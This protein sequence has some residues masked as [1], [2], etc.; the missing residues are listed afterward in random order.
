MSQVSKYLIEK[1][2]INEIFNIFLQAIAD[3]RNKKEVSNFF[4]EFL[5]PTEKTMLAKR[6]A[7]G[8]FLSKGFNYRLISKLLKV[9]TSTV[10]IYNLSYKY[11]NNYKNVVNKILRRKAV[12]LFFLNMSEFIAKVGAIG[13]AKSSGWFEAKK[14]VQKRKKDKV[15]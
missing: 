5:T 4:D 8:V 7:I 15:V 13:G 3:L 1:N 2:T 9:S 12:E 10:S 6:L 11:K 14:Y